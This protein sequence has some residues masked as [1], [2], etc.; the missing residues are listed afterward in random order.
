LKPT[1]PDDLSLSDFVFTAAQIIATVIFIPLRRIKDK[2]DF[3]NLY[4]FD[5]CDSGT[6]LSGSN[7]NR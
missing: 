1:I 3:D 4:N 7:V 6:V 5:R 2:I